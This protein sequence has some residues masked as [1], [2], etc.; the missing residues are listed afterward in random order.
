MIDAMCKAYWNARGSTPWER[1]TEAQRDLIRE[2]MRAALLAQ[3][4]YLPMPVAELQI[5]TETVSAPVNAPNHGSFSELS[6][7][8]ALGFKIQSIT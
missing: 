4:P 8:E 7:F 6:V 5:A 1:E 2:R 3:E